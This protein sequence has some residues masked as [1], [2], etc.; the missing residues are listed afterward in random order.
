VIPIGRNASSLVALNAR[1]GG[2]AEQDVL[3]G[4]QT[5][6]AR[7]RL[8]AEGLD[9]RFHPGGHLTTHEHPDLLAAT[10]RELADTR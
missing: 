9:V 1:I 5:I 10:I 4:R 6:A 3:E 7:D 2:P 8:Q